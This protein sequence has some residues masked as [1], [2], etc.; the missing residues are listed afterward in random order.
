MTSQL[1]E[2][3]ERVEKEISYADS[4][5]WDCAAIELPTLHTI[6]EAVK[7]PPSEE[8]VERVAREAGKR[9]I[10]H[11]TLERMDAEELHLPDRSFDAAL[12]ALGLMYFPD[13][14]R[15]MRELPTTY[16]VETA[17]RPG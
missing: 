2:A 17:V 4:Q 14:L 16:D 11:A 7:G 15:S 12:C 1:S 5:G 13:P 9:G 8:M 6:L 10:G 3:V